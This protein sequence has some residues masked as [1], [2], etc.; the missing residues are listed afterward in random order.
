M[1]DVDGRLE[2]VQEL[3]RQHGLSHMRV[4]HEPLFEHVQFQFRREVP[5]SVPK[6]SRCASVALTLT[7]L[8]FDV[9]VVWQADAAADSA[10]SSGRQG[11][12]EFHMATLVRLSPSH[13]KLHLYQ[14]NLVP[15]E[16]Y[17]RH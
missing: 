6:S 1:H 13:S 15:V 2:R 10:S 3:C 14:I 9:V 7:L 17:D 5:V 12:G 16:H 11:G 8:T 4:S